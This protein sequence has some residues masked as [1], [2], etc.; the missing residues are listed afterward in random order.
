MYPRWSA[1]LVSVALAGWLQAAEQEGTKIDYQVYSHYFEKNT[2]GLR[3]KASYLGFSNQADFDQ[4]FGAAAVQGKQ[5]FL[6]KDVFDKHNV[7]AVIKRGTRVWT[8]KVDKVT[9]DPDVLY[10]SY[11][12]SSKDG[13][14]AQFAS[15][16]ILA[17]DKGTY[18]FVMFIENGKKVGAANFDQ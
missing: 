3:G 6:P 8:Y 12:A 14:G 16:L 18:N 11:E 1:V 2:S 15:P 13:G 4:V 7:V 10:V 9:V 5:K 17:V